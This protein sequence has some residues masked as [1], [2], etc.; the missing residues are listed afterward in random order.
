MRIGNG[1][2]VHP[3]VPGRAL[4]LGGIVIPYEFGLHGHSDGD[5]LTHAI[6]DALLGAAGLGDIG[7]RFPPGD[8]QFAGMRSLFMLED[9]MRSI[10]DMRLKV[11]NVDSVIICE[12]PKLAP[13]FAGMRE[14]LSAA[15]GIDWDK[16]NVKA[17]TNEGLGFL[18]RGEA[19]AVHAVAL[20]S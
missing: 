20:L 17:T 15:M 18:G 9:C 16:V 12:K 6:I 4:I 8:P 1:Y 19:I 7:M 10:A 11:E 5:A 13:Y 2:D 3:L 14:S